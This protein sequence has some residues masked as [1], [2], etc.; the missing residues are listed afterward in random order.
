MAVFKE[1]DKL[2]SG[3]GIH[4]GTDY[5]ENR[6]YFNSKHNITIEFRY[7]LIVIISVSHWYHIG[8]ISI[9]VELNSNNARFV[10]RVWRNQTLRDWLDQ[11]GGGADL[12]LMNSCLWDMCRYL[13]NTSTGRLRP[14]CPTYT[15]NLDCLLSRLS[16]SPALAPAGQFVWLTAPP[17]MFSPL[18]ASQFVIL[19]YLQ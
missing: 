8:I 2:V 16:S 5:K 6:E 11:P 18:S 3:S 19:Y 14:V 7:K 13:V 4:S 12:V 15:W 9:S 1:K 10:T 17:G